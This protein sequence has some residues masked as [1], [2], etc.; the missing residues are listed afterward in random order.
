MVKRGLRFSFLALPWAL[1]ALLGWLWL[2]SALDMSFS[3]I[4]AESAR[5][6]SANARRFVTQLGLGCVSRQMIIDAAETR[7]WD[8]RDAPHGYSGC[9]RPD[10]LS[11]WLS[12]EVQPPL[13]M[14]SYDE[15][16]LYFGFD[17]HGCMAPWSPGRGAG[18]TCPDR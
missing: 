8:W 5:A 7:G 13:M 18:S 1:T 14:S 2:D 6:N 11:D 16:A 9:I 4:G 12:V 10:G 15:N 3:D 17:A